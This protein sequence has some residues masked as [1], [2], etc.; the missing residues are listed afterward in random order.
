MYFVCDLWFVFV[1]SNRRF[2]FWTN[3]CQICLDGMCSTQD[4]SLF[5][6]LPSHMQAACASAG[7]KK[8]TAGTKKGTKASIL[9]TSQLR[10][11]TVVWLVKVQRVRKIWWQWYPTVFALGRRPHKWRLNF[12]LPVKSW[13]QYFLLAL[14][15]GPF[16]SHSALNNG[17]ERQSKDQEIWQVQRNFWCWFFSNYHSIC[18]FQTGTTNNQGWPCIMQ[19]AVLLVVTPG[20]PAGLNS[21][22]HQMISPAFVF[23]LEGRPQNPSVL[24]RHVI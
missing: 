9:K 7:T 15:M 4:G 1:V 17:R 21:S 12:S 20:W 13:N 18:F 14:L 5:M 3:E 6:F 2:T 23:F 10:R 8:G 19:R 16:W 22:L 11:K 24:A